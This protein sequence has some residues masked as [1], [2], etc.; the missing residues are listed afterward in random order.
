MRFRL[1]ICALLMCATGIARADGASDNLPDSVRRI[2]PPGITITEPDRAE[3]QSGADALGKKIDDLKAEYQQNPG[4]M[5]LL[6][7]IQIFHNAVRYALK[8]N[9]FYNP[10]E[11]NVA[12]DLLKAGN[13]RADELKIGKASW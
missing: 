12:R 10:R 6:P 3:L 1:L 7:D 9:E 11:V 4:K 5:D 13:A 8:Y 2:P